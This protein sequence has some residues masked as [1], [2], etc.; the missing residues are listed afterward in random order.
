[1]E[2]RNTSEQAVFH[3]LN[4]EFHVRTA[5]VVEE[6]CKLVE[7]GFE[8]VDTVDGVHIYRKRK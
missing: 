3:K 2:E 1:M 4:E 6:A 7:V 8:Y 5:K